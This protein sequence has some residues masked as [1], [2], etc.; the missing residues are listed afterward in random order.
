MERLELYT[1]RHKCALKRELGFGYDGI[2]FSTDCQSALKAFRFAALFQRERDVYQR[3]HENE[4]TLVRGFE[5]PQVIRA[6]EEIWVIKM[7]IV[8]SPFVLDFAGALHRR[9]TMSSASASP[10]TMTRPSRCSSRPLR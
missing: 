2:V 4:V 8:S 1:Q 5:V 10:I 7:S 6:D 3:L 9:A